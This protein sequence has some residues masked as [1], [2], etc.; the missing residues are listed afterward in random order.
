MTNIYDPDD[1]TQNVISQSARANEALQEMGDDLAQTPNVYLTQERV[2]AAAIRTQRMRSNLSQAQ[3]A[4][5]M[6]QKGFGML[7]TTVAKIEAGQ[8]PI[9][10]AEVFAFADSLNVPWLAL[11]IGRDENEQ[12]SMDHMGAILKSYEDQQAGILQ[13]MTKT[14]EIFARTYAEAGVKALHYAAE[15]RRAGAEAVGGTDGSP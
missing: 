15:M 1:A 5:R 11:M 13:S 6:S 2:M 14:L 12:T 10:M 3:L 8:R 7:Q 9:R 4:A